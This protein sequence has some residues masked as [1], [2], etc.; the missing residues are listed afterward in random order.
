MISILSKIDL[1]TI[2]HCSGIQVSHLGG[3]KQKSYNYLSIILHSSFNYL[4]CSSF[5]VI[6]SG[7]G[8]AL[9]AQRCLLLFLSHFC[10]IF[11]IVGGLCWPL[12][13][14]RRPWNVS[15]LNKM[16]QKCNNCHFFVVFYL[17]MF[18]REET[19]LE[20]IIW[21]KCNRRG[22]FCQFFCH[23]FEMAFVAV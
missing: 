3:L 21:Q 7:W 12:M 22:N 8:R 10:H 6:I 19:F 14:Y 15:I 9:P 20:T 4:T 5:L 1:S 16:W 23:I 17:L 11:G 2:L 18:P 13:V